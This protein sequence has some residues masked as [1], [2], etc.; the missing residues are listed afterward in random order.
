MTCT[1]FFISF[2]LLTAPAHWYGLC[3]CISGFFEKFPTPSAF[4]EADMNVVREIMYPLGLFDIR[5]KT[6]TELSKKVAFAPYVC[7]VPCTTNIQM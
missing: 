3:S 1:A 6:L 5:L 2:P 7:A 4:I